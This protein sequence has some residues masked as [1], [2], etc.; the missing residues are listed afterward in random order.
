M[1]KFH[2]EHAQKFTVFSET[3]LGDSLL[4]FTKFYFVSFHLGLKYLGPHEF[5]S[6]LLTS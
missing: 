4:V 5:Y 2:P 1:D 3:F 6:Y